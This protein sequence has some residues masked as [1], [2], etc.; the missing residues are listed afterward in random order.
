MKRTAGLTV[1]A[2]SRVNNRSAG[3]GMPPPAVLPL[4]QNHE[5]HTSPKPGEHV[6]TLQAMVRSCCADQFSGKP[7]LF[8]STKPQI[9]AEKPFWEF[10]A[11]WEPTQSVTYLF[12][13]LMEKIV[14]YS[15]LQNALAPSFL[16]NQ[17]RIT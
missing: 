8:M 10:L 14:L 17:N 4:G 2:A 16:L 1:P 11:L 9:F 5:L 15:Y 3:T 12:F 7:V 13:F 6:S